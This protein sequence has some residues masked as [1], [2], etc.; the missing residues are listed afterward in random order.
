MSST[1]LSAPVP[2]TPLQEF[3]YY[4]CQNRG[5]VIGLAFI[6]IV[7][8]MAIFAEWVA[9]FDPITQ[10]RSALLLPPMWFEGGNAS[11]ILGTDDIGRDILSRIIHGARL[12]VFIGL[13]IVVM[14]CVLGVILGLLAGYYG[15]TLDILIMRFVDIMLAIPSLLLTIGVVTILGPSLMNAAIAIA[16]VSIPSYVR[17]T[18]ASVMSEKNRDY[19]VASRV[20]GAS[21]WRLMFIVILPNCLAPLIVQMTMGISNAIL[22]LAALGFLGI[23]AQPPT[24]E[25]GTMLAESRGFMQS[26]NWLVTIPGLAILSLVLAFNLMGD[27]LRDALDP[28]LKQ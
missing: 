8:F 12:S 2:K 14:S 21:V 3:W 15:G 24:P 20:A 7:L 13:L 18:R 26:A 9:P 27:G 1:T 5:A 6:V 4:F 11:Y 25:L 28:K 23:G 22:E 16:I 19:V 17:L 10:N